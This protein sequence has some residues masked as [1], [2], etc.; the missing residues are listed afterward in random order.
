MADATV[1][2]RWLR[3]ERKAWLGTM[4]C[5]PLLPARLLPSDYAGCAAWRERLKVMAE[6][7]N[8]MR[9]FMAK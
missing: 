5:N 2:Q 4:E 3:A 6:A 1:L 7:G 8:Q 9:G